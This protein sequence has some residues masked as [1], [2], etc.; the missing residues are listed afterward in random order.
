MERIKKLFGTKVKP[1][2]PPPSQ[3]HS[4]A[5]KPSVKRPDTELSFVIY[6]VRMIRKRDRTRLSHHVVFL[7]YNSGVLYGRNVLLCLQS[8]TKNVHIHQSGNA[9]IVFYGKRNHTINRNE[10]ANALGKK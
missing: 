4:R 6:F 1:L 8:I 5:A 9:E 3:Y 2:L 10:T 7:T